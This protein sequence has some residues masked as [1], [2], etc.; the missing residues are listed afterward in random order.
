MAF[1][2]IVSNACGVMFGPGVELKESMRESRRTDMR[3]TSVILGLLAG[4]ANA[5]ERPNVLFIVCDDLNR[6]VSTSAYE[7]IKTPVLDHLAAEGMTFNRA[8]CQYPVCGPSRASFLSGLYPES[9]GVIDNKAD[10][11]QTRPGTASLP[12]VF[13][14]NGYWTAHVGKVFHT[15]NTDPGDMAWNAKGWFSNDELAVVVAAKKNFEAEHG[16]IEERRNRKAWKE[17]R[18]KA[19]GLLTSQT[20]PGHGPSGLQDAQHKDG[21]NVRQVAK[22][23]REQAHGDKPFFITCGIQK[24]HVPFLAPD[25]YFAMY[26]QDGIRYLE[27]P[28]DDLKDV[29]PTALVKRAEAFGFEMG[30]ENDSLRREYMQ[31]YHAC[32]TF[33]DTQLKIM[34]DALKERGLWDNTIVIFTS[35]HGY[36]LGEHYLWGKVSLFEECAR[37]PLIVRVPGMTEAGS[38]TEAMVEHVDI[39]PTLAQLCEVKAPGHLQG[40]SFVPVLREPKRPLRED[41]YTVVARQTRLG[42]AIRTERWRYADWEMPGQFELYDLKNDPRELTNLVKKAKYAEVV[43]MMKKRLAARRKGA[44]SERGQ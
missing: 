8:Y 10:I 18:T 9:T 25:K 3:L 5:A 31:A 19:A 37:V 35:D 2:K 29:P 1:P 11:R 34:F 4:V 32:V 30:V 14:E 36:H 7:H 33:V 23:V 26:P 40:R 43:V 13:K 24:P 41:V 20:P 28:E 27:N 44:S 39:F 38:K 16:S 12:Q 17:A 22:W 15:P 42:R 21:K 6:H